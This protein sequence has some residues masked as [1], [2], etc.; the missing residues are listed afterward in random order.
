MKNDTYPLEENPL[1]KVE[2]FYNELLAHYGSGKDREIRAAAKLLL[3][4]LDKFRQFGGQ[5]W[6]SLVNEYVSLISENPEK[7]DLMMKCHRGESDLCFPPRLEGK[8]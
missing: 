7:F 5:H 2:A 3:V 4:A 1:I 6:M 8:L